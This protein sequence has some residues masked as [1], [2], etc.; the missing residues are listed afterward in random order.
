MLIILKLG[1]SVITRKEADEPTINH[2]NL[3][4]I[5]R[6]IAE[7]NYQKLILVHGAGSFGHP[8]AKK[9]TIGDEIKDPTD[10]K[11]KIQGFSLTHDSVNE[12]NHTVCEYLRMQEIPAVPIPPSSFILT[13]N[14]RIKIADLSLIKRYLELGFI[15][16]LY[17]DVVLDEDES[18]KMAVLSGDQIITYMARKLK[19]E[20]VILATDVDGIYNKNPKKNH[21]A[22]LI[23]TVSSTEQIETGEETTVDVTGGM[24]GKITE[25]LDLLD[26]NIESLIINA[27]KK[28]RITKAINGE[29]VTG[30]TIKR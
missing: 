23:E 25:L 12:L 29:K 17:G 3:K 20:R 5:F 9:Y 11:R 24:G 27:N 8:Y 28:D 18:I 7:S 21:D 15:P 14:K 26:L 4:R 6:E 30:T 16:V 22:N 10:L 19:P 2:D 1:G 13:K